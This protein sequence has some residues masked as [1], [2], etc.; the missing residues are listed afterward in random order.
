VSVGRHLRSFALRYVIAFLVATAVMVGAVV[1]TNKVIDA[2]IAKITRV[3]LDLTPEPPGG[4]NYLVIGSDTRQFGENA[5]D[6]KAFGDPRI[7]TGQRSDTIMLVHVEPA[8]QRTMIVSF[9]RDLR[10]KIDGFSGTT[11]INTAFGAGAQK[12][13]DTITQNF[14]IPIHHYIE[15]NFKSFRGIVD[16]IG[17]VPVYVPLPMRDAGDKEPVNPAVGPKGNLG[18]GFRV[19][20]PGCYNLNGDQALQW[21]RARHMWEQNPDTKRWALLDIGS[22]INRIQRQQDFIR[23]LM[24]IAVRQSLGDPFTANTVANNIVKNLT[25]D[26][27][28]TKHDLLSLVDAFRTSNPNDPTN[29]EMETFPWLPFGD[30]ATLKPD[31]EKDA[32]VIARLKDFSGNTQKPLDVQPSTI[33]VEVRNATG[34]N[35]LA[36]QSL[37]LLKRMNGFLGTVATNDP[38][39]TVAENE[40][41]YAPGKRE[42]AIVV[43]GAISPAPRLSEDPNLKGV[44]VAVVLG[45][46][47]QAIV[48]LPTVTPG[49]GASNTQATP[50]T[51]PAKRPK[52]KAFAKPEECV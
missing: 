32:A 20:F 17:G 12:V 48:R 6:Q 27:A 38:R 49:G 33:T 11:R 42:Q 10:V 34:T 35:G 9:P 36:K 7:E 1:T 4:A 8:A 26:K 14:G 25:A 50:V 2:K 40:V 30:N 41:R 18:S 15:I 51:V 24:S 44:D 28:L 13:A 29:F 19:D 31:P 16:A 37:A 5:A 3:T 43:L 46:N 21:V 45:R 47:F 23:R 39:G 22:D 52:G